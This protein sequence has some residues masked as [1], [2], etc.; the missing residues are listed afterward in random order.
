MYLGLGCQK[1]M[2]H[3]LFM[4]YM[5]SEKRMNS[6]AIGSAYVYFLIAWFVISKP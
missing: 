5:I 2:M 1:A 6:K 3:V 4:V